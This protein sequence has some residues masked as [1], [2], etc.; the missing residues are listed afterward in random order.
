MSLVVNRITQ[1]VYVQK[2]Y[3]KVKKVEPLTKQIIATGTSLMLIGG[4]T[5]ATKKSN[6]ALSSLIKSFVSKTK[7]YISPI[8]SSSVVKLSNLNSD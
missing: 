4:T 1:N 7:E 3:S 6:V 8:L 5:F 2:G